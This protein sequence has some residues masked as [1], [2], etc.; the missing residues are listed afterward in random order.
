MDDNERSTGFI[1]N[2]DLTFFSLYRK[3]TSEQEIISII[4][5]LVSLLISCF[6]VLL[7]KYVN[8][9]SESMSFIFNSIL[10]ASIGILS[11]LIAAFGLFAAITD[12]NFS[13]KIYKLGQLRNI[14]FP[15][16]FCSSMW[17]LNIFSSMTFI[18]LQKITYINSYCLNIVFYLF[19]VLFV[20]TI[21][22]TLALIG[23]ILKLSIHR[24]QLDIVESSTQHK[25][26]LQLGFGEA[27]N[28]NKDYFR[29]YDFLRVIVLI[30]IF[31][32]FI[33]FYLLK[34]YVVIT[35]ITGAGVLFLSYWFYKLFTKLK[36][37]NQKTILKRLNSLL[38]FIIFVFFSW[39]AILVI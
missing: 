22:Y 18:L 36:R 20:I 27:E 10:S 15:F 17:V 8:N 21:G 11:V 29:L 9:I 37:D 25:N 23:D 7:L 39:I 30:A 3:Y 6:F 2:R 28:I 34:K 13:K 24:I 35:L 19:F 14:L 32:F 38:K 4:H 26:I 12:I 31:Y 33:W 5:L 1:R 16:W